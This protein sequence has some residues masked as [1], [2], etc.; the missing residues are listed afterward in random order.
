MLVGG[1]LSLA[2]VYFRI[3]RWKAHTITQE[4]ERLARDIH[5][6]MAQSFAGIGYQI[7]GIR[8]GVVG[9]DPLNSSDIADQLT[10][11]YQ[12]VRRCHEEA[13][14]TIAMLA[15]IVPPMQQNLL[16]SLEELARRVATCQIKIIVESSGAP[17]QL[18]L[19]LADALVHI[20]REAIVNALAHSDP[21]V[22]TIRLKHALNSVDLEVEDNGCGFE[23][24][25]ETAGFGIVG[26]QKRARDVGASLHIFSTPGRGTLVRITAK[27]QHENL[28]KR[29]LSRSGNGLQ[30]AGVNLHE[31]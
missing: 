3:Q 31:R 22:L 11:A 5:D 8:H 30:G 24:S 4:R 2:L 20:G 16:G 25:A 12:L 15:S 13:S 1:T 17:S 7:Q 27:L 18:K 9:G 14:R 29:V 23:Y 10:V 19:R 28:L 6:T 26:M 21:T